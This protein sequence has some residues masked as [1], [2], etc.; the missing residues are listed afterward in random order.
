[1]PPRGRDPVISGAQTD[2]LLKWRPGGRGTRVKA[3][4]YE[5]AYRDKLTKHDENGLFAKAARCRTSM[6]E[7]PPPPPPTLS[8]SPLPAADKQQFRN[9]SRTKRIISLLV[10]IRNL[11]I[12]DRW[13][14]SSRSEKRAVRLIALGFPRSR[15]LRQFPP[16]PRFSFARRESI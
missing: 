9:D 11:Q 12:V 14:D 3:F 13:M 1:M 16:D 7:T 8:P 10:T 2:R 6:P 4:P 5:W 15:R